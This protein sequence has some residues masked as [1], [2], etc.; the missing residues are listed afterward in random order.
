LF[1]YRVWDGFLSGLYDKTNAVVIEENR[2]VFIPSDTCLGDKSMG[3]LKSAI[4]LIETTTKEVFFLHLAKVLKSLSMLIIEIR[5]HCHFDSL[6]QDMVT[7][8]ETQCE[9]NKLLSRFAINMTPV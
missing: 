2:E 1:S 5:E 3:Y 4:K 8:C 9:P 6:V 7:F